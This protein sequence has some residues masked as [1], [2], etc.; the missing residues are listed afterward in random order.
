[1]LVENICNLKGLDHVVCIAV[2]AETC[3]YTVTHLL[4][5]RRAAA[6]VAHVR[7]GIVD[8]HRISVLYEL[9]LVFIDVDAVAEKRLRTEDV[10]IVE[11]V[12][13]TLSVFLQAVMQV[14]NTF[15]DMD[16][17]ADFVRLHRCCVIKCLIRDRELRMHAHHACN[18]VGIICKRIFCPG[19]VLIHRLFRFI[20]AIPV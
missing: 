5:G 17:I 4:H 11:A 6:C 7:F 14:F 12:D 16:V 8:D 2:G 1:M 9:H 15:S 20:H 3:Q 10:V 13:D 18:H 19:R